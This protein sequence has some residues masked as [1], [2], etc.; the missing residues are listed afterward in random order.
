M[1]LLPM[2]L[3]SPLGW[4]VILVAVGYMVWTNVGSRDGDVA[5][6][7]DK[8]GTGEAA[9]GGGPPAD[10][11]ARFVGFVLD[12][13]QSTWAKIFEEQGKQYPRAK[14]VLFTDATQTGCG[15][16]QAATGPFYCP[17]D[18]RVYIDLGFWKELSNKLG[19]KGEFAQAY[20]IAHEVG[21][22]VQDTLGISDKAG[23]AKGAE[24][25]S[26]RLELQADCFAGI[27][28][29]STAQRD[30]L[31]NG[32]L[33]SALNAAQSIGDDRL[34]RMQK[35]TVRPESFT[36][37]SSEQRERWFKKG[38]ES[39]RMADCDTFSAGSL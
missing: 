4:L 33:D 34:Q 27:W 29:H 20:V 26:V 11:E 14:L 38:Y 17:T 21:H 3:R 10:R 16:G 31:E 35:G 37:G 25:G 7:P 28:A 39:G 30:L 5:Q 6:N 32:D 36:H 2:L 9:K 12:D 8:P 1:Y 18:N 23:H 13:A 24:G 19:A 15:Y 22:H